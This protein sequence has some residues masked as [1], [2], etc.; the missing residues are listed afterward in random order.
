MK[1]LKN[2]KI[3]LALLLMPFFIK[4][5]AQTG[6]K[7]SINI[8]LDNIYQATDDSMCVLSIEYPIIS[9]M[10]DTL[11]E[12]KINH[13]LNEKFT[14]VPDWFKI[15]DCDSTRGLAYDITFDVPFN[16]I[17]FLSIIQQYYWFSGGA[18][19]NYGYIGFNIDLQNGNIYNLSDV[20]KSDGFDK[21]TEIAEYKIKEIYNTDNLKDAGLFDDHLTITKEQNYFITD[22]ALV[23]QFNPYEIAPYAYGDIEVEIPFDQISDIIK[24]NLP[25]IKQNIKKSLDYEFKKK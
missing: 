23:L 24:P 16:S 25:F 9:G 14:P 22:T 13:F 7:D 15:K 4:A 20:I 11:L 6:A 2:I 10:D 21:L 5:Y 1:N 8:L 3:F 17:N 12:H 18:H 19:G